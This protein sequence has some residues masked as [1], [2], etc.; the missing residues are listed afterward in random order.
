MS[1]KKF[2]L[3]AE[4]ATAL[5]EIKLRPARIEDARRIQV[6]Y[7]E[8]YGQHYT[9]PIVYDRG[10]MCRA[11]EGDSHFWLVAEHKGRIIASLVYSVD[12]RARIAKALGAVVSKQ[13]RKNNLAN[14]M[15]KAMAKIS[16]YFANQGHG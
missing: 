16:G 1:Q 10:L 12:I 4:T 13:Y 15:M 5:P 11:I 3:M 14:M 2:K 8:V 9:I 6:L 7:A